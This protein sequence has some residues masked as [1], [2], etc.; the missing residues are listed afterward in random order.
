M[1]DTP[2]NAVFVIAAISVIIFSLVGVG[3]MTGVI[4]TS[5]SKPRD[6]KTAP[7]TAHAEAV[8]SPATS[9]NRSEQ[10]VQGKRAAGDSTASRSASER[11]VPAQHS[12]ADCG[13]VEMISLVE[14]TETPSAPVPGAEIGKRAQTI[15]LARY[16]VLVRLADGTARTFS[17]EAQPMFRAGDT[18][19]IVGS[20]LV[21]N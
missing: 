11:L 5:I 15:R 7:R 21:A 19:R 13:R 18:V 20:T 10:P 9:G 3:V 14:P 2:S 1:S 17:Y 8:A 12:C 6:P 16:D 4:P